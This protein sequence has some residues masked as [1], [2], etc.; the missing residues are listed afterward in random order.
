MRKFLVLGHPIAHSLS[1]EIHA[2]FGRI[3]G[4]D[5]QYTKMDV[6]PGTFGETVDELRREGVCG[7]NVTVPYKLEAMAVSDAVS[8][9]ARK[10]GAVNTLKFSEKIY[11]DNT[12]GQGF[13][14]DVSGR[15]EFDFSDRRILLCGTGGAARGLLAVLVSVGAKSITLAHRSGD[16]GEDLAREFSVAHCP[17]RELAGGYDLIVNATSSSMQGVRLDLSRECFSGV[18]LAYDL[19]YSSE[20]TVFMRQAMEH[21]VARAVDGLGMLVGQA[22]VS[23]ELWTGVLPPTGSVYAMLEKKI[24]RCAD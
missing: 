14:N 13:L 7:A 5:I 16:N 4:L 17:Y 24:R 20:P 8:E 12:D 9:R 1:P 21:G 6:H 23:F 3:C 19:F 22:A 18:Q 11:G 2:E 10:A 15:L